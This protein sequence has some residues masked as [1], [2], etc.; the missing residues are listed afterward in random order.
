MR[1]NPNVIVSKIHLFL[2]IYFMK[3]TKIYAL[4]GNPRNYY[5]NS[6]LTLLK[7]PA[8]EIHHVRQFRI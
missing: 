7:I 3:L 6:R 8:I 5:M 4:P 2:I 1:D